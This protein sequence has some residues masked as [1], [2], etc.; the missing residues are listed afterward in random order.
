MQME[1]TEKALRTPCPRENAR[2]N[3]TIALTSQMSVAARP[4]SAYISAIPPATAAKPV[5]FV[6]EIPRNALAKP[7]IVGTHGAQASATPHRNRFCFRSSTYFV[8]F[9]RFLAATHSGSPLRD[10]FAAGVP[11]KNLAQP[12]SF[13]GLSPLTPI[14]PPIPPP[15]STIHPKFP[16]PTH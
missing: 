12:I 4:S 1:S 16:L 8:P 2:N 14:S 11:S 7:I 10:C 9:P 15:P 3:N 5:A 6:F 13:T